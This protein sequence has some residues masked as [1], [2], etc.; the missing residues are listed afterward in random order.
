[1]KFAKPK[2]RSALEDADRPVPLCNACG[3]PFDARG[4][5]VSCGKTMGAAAPPPRTAASKRPVVKPTPPKGSPVARTTKPRPPA[6]KAHDTAA[7]PAPPPPPSSKK[8]NLRRPVKDE[9][10]EDDFWNGLR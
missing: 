3:E 7:M 8:P 2:T 6:A 9:D 5:C 10:G 4:R 1:M